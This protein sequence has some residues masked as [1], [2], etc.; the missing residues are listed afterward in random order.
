MIKKI[1]FLILIPCVALSQQLSTENILYDGNNR[2]YILYIPQTYSPSIL[3]PILFAF[4]GG[5]GFA[6]NFMNNEADFRAISD[7]AGFIL[8]Y[9]QA[10]EDPNDGNSTNWF[11]KEPTNHNDI[12]FFMKSR[13]L[14]IK[15]L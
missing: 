4:H 9:P 14:I 10:L 13:N 8:V 3:T 7:T 11:H 15:L 1:V 6:N 5:S 2:E 12:F